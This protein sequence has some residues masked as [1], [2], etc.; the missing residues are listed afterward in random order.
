MKNNILKVMVI[1]MIRYKN[2]VY[3]FINNKDQIIY[4]GKALDLEK[5]LNKRGHRSG[6]LQKQ[7]Y[8]EIAVIEYVEL[9]NENDM[10]FAEKY[11]IQKYNPIYNDVYANKPISIEIKD[12]DSMTWSTYSINEKEVLR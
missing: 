2:C 10:D 7:C 9:E 8:D 5:R 4:S 6:H 3:R 12:L 1:I 11:Y